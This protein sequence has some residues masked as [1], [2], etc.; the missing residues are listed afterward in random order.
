MQTSRRS[1]RRPDDQ[2]VVKQRTCQGPCEYRGL[3][4]ARYQVRQ[5]LTVLQADIRCPH[6][7]T[8]KG[9][10]PPPRRVGVFQG[11]TVSVRAPSVDPLSSQPKREDGHLRTMGVA[12]VLQPKSRVMR[13]RPCVSPRASSFQDG[14][15]RG[16]SVRVGLRGQVA[17]GAGPVGLVPARNP[18]MGCCVKQSD[19]QQEGIPTF[20]PSPASYLL[21]V[22]GR[23]PHFRPGPTTGRSPQVGGWGS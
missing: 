18:S 16:A 12:A 3:L 1:R 11:T 10:R 5:G 15:A 2:F 9:R 8:T 4:G 14:S 22:L 6:P 7:R 17:D 20:R 13:Q 19:K 23:W 21:M